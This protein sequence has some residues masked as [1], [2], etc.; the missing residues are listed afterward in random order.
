[1][2]LPARNASA[3]IARAINSIRA[4]SFG[5]FELLAIDDGSTDDTPTQLADAARSDPR[6][7]V[8]RTSG[9]GLVGALNLGL[10]SARAPLIARMD[11][12]DE[13]LPLR[14]ERSHQALGDLT[15]TGVGTGVEIARDDRPASPN[16]V[17]YGAWLSSLT[18]REKLFADRFVESPLCHPSVMLRTEPLRAF[19]GWHDGPFPED[20][21]LWLR[22][23]EGGHHLE[24]LGERLHRWFDHDHRLTRTDD[25]YG[26]ASHLTLKADFLARRFEGQPLSLWG[27]GEI[28]VKLTRALVDRGLTVTRLIDVNPR[29]IGQRIHGARVV[30]PDDLGEPGREH[31]LSAV[32]A[33]GARA[34]I[35]AYLGSRGWF[36][37]LH[38][39]CVA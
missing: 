4:Q 39:T 29:K 7:H 6:I 11:A 31:L 2:L 21:E 22:L 8:L 38:F 16:L 23:L 10:A 35:R 19:G 25:R 37:G 14:F 34:E 1:M 28:G 18:S 27:A 36:E 12:D 17:A 33:K 13:S 9:V 32:G 3:T 24:C 30:L 20:W 26:T 5:D 15:L